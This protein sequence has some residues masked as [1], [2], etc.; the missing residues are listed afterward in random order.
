[1]ATEM[2]P[3]TA[4]AVELNSKG[5]SIEEIA[6]RLADRIEAK[7]KVKSIRMRLIKAG[8]SL[9]SSDTKKNPAGER[10]A[11]LVAEL[12]ALLGKDCEDLARLN[13]STLRMLINK[14]S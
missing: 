14:L 5:V 13:K 7:D 8:V 3:I 12:N 6:N 11:D 4:E 2:N 10:A 1:M 9:P